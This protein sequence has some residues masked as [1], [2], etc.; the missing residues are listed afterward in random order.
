MI[1]FTQKAINF[2]LD[3]KKMK[4]LGVYPKGYW[5]VK[6]SFKEHG[7]VHRQGSGY[8][9]VKELSNHATRK[10]IKKI[11]RE[12]PWI[13]PCVKAYDI[14]EVGE[15]Y[16]VTNEVRKWAGESSEKK[17][18]PKAPSQKSEQAK[19][20][21]GKL[22]SKDEE[23]LASIRRSVKCK[24]FDKLY[25]GEQKGEQAEKQLM[26]MLAFFSGENQE[27]MQRIFESS[28][29]YNAGKGTEYVAALCKQAIE[30][31]ALKPNMFN[32]H[33][34]NRNSGKTR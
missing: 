4:E 15:Q 1:F 5:L 28:A 23:L 19:N 3:T 14:T 30:K 17:L 22:N 32:T 20:T 25:R 10:I 12:N 24:E 8:V 16:D 9:S 2:D 29:Q 31:G 13:G 34:K 26:N 21:K 27:Q 6:K 33:T 11:T 18:L 7:F